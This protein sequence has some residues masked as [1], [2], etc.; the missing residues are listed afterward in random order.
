MAQEFVRSQRLKAGGFGW[1]LHRS[2]C[3]LQKL[4]LPNF[5]VR[6]IW[7]VSGSA[8]LLLS[9]KL[10]TLEE[11]FLF[12]TLNLEVLVFICLVQTLSQTNLLF[13]TPLVPFA[14]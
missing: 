7:C 12:F 3:V 9:V 2:R 5:W 10:P 6:A 8:R 4:T 11:R 14:A 13:P 1:P